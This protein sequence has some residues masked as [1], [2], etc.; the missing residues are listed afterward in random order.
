MNESVVT[1]DTL[2][3][4]SVCRTPTLFAPEAATNAADHVTPPSIE[5]SAAAPASMPVTF[6]VPTFVIL[7]E[8]LRP[9]SLV[10]ATVGADTDVSNVNTSVPRPDTFPATSVWR[11]VTVLR[12]CAGA[13]DVVQVV[14]PL[15]E[16]STFA[17]VSTPDSDSVPTRVIRSVALTPVSFNSDTPGDTGAV[18]S[19]VKEKNAVSETFPPGVMERMAIAL[20]PSEGTNA[21]LHTV[22]PPA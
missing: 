11:T 2:P 12:P 9:V 21:L 16:Y 14:P 5:Y 15:P 6:S 7:S 19:R 4:T 13:Y 8:L 18:V 17:P 22:S 1:D 20:K 10:N 3:A